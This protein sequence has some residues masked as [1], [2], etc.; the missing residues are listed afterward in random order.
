[1]LRNNNRNVFHYILSVR[2]LL[3]WKP[4]F[5]HLMEQKILQDLQ[6]QI[7]LQTDKQSGLELHENLI[8]FSSGYHTGH[9]EQ[10][11]IR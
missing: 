2:E 11:Q 8:S 3:L 1:M 9:L 5:H 6:R 10:L 7:N 4:S